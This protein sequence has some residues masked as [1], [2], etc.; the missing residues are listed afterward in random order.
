MRFLRVGTRHAHPQSQMTPTSPH[1]PSALPWR[2]WLVR[3]VDAWLPETADAELQRRA[4]ILIGCAGLAIGVVCLLLPVNLL[5]APRAV[6]P[7]V[8]LLFVLLAIPVMIKRRG[9]LE[10]AGLLFNVTVLVLVQISAEARGGLQSTTLGWCPVC[11]V[12]GTLTLSPRSAFLMTLLWAGSSFGHALRV[13]LTSWDSARFGP[14]LAYAIPRAMACFATLGAVSIFESAR[15]R[16]FAQLAAEQEQI[17]AQ[18]DQIA[19]ING[20][21]EQRNGDLRLVLD[22]IEQGLFILDQNAI[23]APERSRVLGDWFGPIGSSETFAGLLRR[24]D[25]LAAREFECGWAF[26]HDTEMPSEVVLAQLPARVACGGRALQLAFKPL[27]QSNSRVLVIITDVTPIL[28]QA[29]ADTERR[30]L[31]HIFGEFMKDRAGV[32]QFFDDTQRLIK[33]ISALEPDRDLRRDLHTLKGNAAL[34][35]LG[36]LAALVHRVEEH[37]AIG[38]ERAA[39]ECS[40]L[41]QAWS[42]IQSQVRPWLI[43]ARGRLDIAQSDFEDVHGAIAAGASHSVLQTLLARCTQ[44]DARLY[45]ERLRERALLLASRL[46]KGN[47]R[48]EV[49]SEGV[50]LDPKRWGEF[51]KVF[52]HVVNNAVDHGIEPTVERLER[53]KEAVATL[54]LEV[55]QADGEVRVRVRDDGR[56]I[57][58]HGL[59]KK[60]AEQGLARSE[61]WPPLELL[62]A[63]GL[64]SRAEVSETSGRGVGMWAVKEAA[65]AL[66]ARI[67]I[68]SVIGQF[69]EFE[70]R[71]PADAVAALKA[72]EKV[73]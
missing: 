3:R 50:R 17:R 6:P 39:L 30:E 16:A 55:E 64:S 24:C 66:G 29:K 25:A 40:Q 56:G 65:D 63:P 37:L 71:V 26:L 53:G 38:D 21:L 70:F 18:R 52:V 28:A 69:T 11:V 73:A 36:S 51:W 15:K 12:V 19:F 44:D 9:A 42:M 35:G 2:L 22:T 41:L 46:G 5:I 7:S 45:L 59:A 10:C 13:D 4:R 14:P 54:R 60:A 31:L 49:C 48:V 32:R 20:R 61:S 67:S 8:L 27:D 34:F 43:D 1:P 47:V 68:R 58:W 33:K 72:V 62:F 57:D 23:I